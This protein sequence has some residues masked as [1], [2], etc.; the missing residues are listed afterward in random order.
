MAA[1][2]WTPAADYILQTWVGISPEL[3]MNCLVPLNIFCGFPIV[4]SLRS[5]IHGI[6]LLHHRTQAM[7]P[8]APS[9]VATVILVLSA[10]SSVDLHGATRATIALLSGHTVETLVVWWS[11]RR[12]GKEMEVTEV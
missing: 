8:S 4:V 10:L 7:A 2:V 12:G 11:I 1:I 5:Y 3:A 6:G 9:R